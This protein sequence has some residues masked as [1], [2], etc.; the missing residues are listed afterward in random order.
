MTQTVTGLVQA[1]CNFYHLQ[2]DDSSVISDAGKI[3]YELNFGSG[4]GIGQVNQLWHQT[5]SLI[6]YEGIDMAN[7]PSHPLGLSTSKS[8]YGAGGANVKATHI[9]NSSSYN[10][11]VVLPFIDSDGSKWIIVP[12]SGHL[13]LSNIKG[14]TVPN[15]GAVIEISG[16]G[17]QQYYSISLIGAALP[18]FIDRAIGIPI[19]YKASSYFDK[20]INIEYA[21]TS[22]SSAGLIPFEYL[23]TPSG[24]SLG[25][26]PIEYLA[27]P[28]GSSLFNWENIASPNIDKFVNIEWKSSGIGGEASG[29][30]LRNT[31]FL[32]GG[33]G[34][35]FSY[36]DGI[37][38][39]SG[40][41][42]W[43]FIWPTGQLV[44]DKNLSMVE[45]QCRH[46][47]AIWRF[48]PSG[49]VW[50]SN[51]LL[52]G[53]PFSRF[54]RYDFTAKQEVFNVQSGV[55]YTLKWEHEVDFPASYRPNYVD[56]PYFQ[57]KSKS[58]TILSGAHF[59]KTHP[60]LQTF[61]TNIVA[62]DDG[63][64]LEWIMPRIPWYNTINP[65]PWR[66]EMDTIDISS[67]FIENPSIKKT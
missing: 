35:E 32:Y 58:G 56:K 49:D 60:P 59:D 42:P 9:D 54:H 41:P 31:D 7:L 67:W 38:D 33:T 64:V 19:E 52:L 53:S 25:E 16:N 44:Q 26:I 36:W 12:P 5:K 55:T 8:F 21:K 18:I 46:F 47:F 6:T 3:D 24:S 66:P 11:G 57:L 4:T 43:Q 39:P 51:Y 48:S 2:K 61:S 63:F 1:Q 10:I 65:V 14:W 45:L 34:Q 20:T 13:T 28:S 22:F 27:G 50:R 37:A 15:T 17:T 62:I 29:E 23:K 30:L 40:V